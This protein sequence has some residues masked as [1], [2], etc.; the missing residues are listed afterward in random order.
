MDTALG[1]AGA[2][3]H[4]VFSKRVRSVPKNPV[5]FRR[6][7]GLA[8][9]LLALG[10][11]GW[12]RNLAEAD[13]LENWLKSHPPSE[14]L[15]EHSLTLNHFQAV[16]E[17]KPLQHALRSLPSSLDEPQTVWLSADSNWIAIF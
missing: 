4:G 6:L 7:L 2:W 13:A 3:L 17:G 11:G 8:L 9:L 1:R 10:S 12:A 14:R 16:R 5:L 15:W